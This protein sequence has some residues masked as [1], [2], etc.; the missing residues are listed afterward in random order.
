MLIFKRLNVF[1][2]FLLGF[3]LNYG[4]EFRAGTC[5]TSVRMY[6]QVLL[7]NNTFFLH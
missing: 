4:Q 6:E 7:F 5:T 2:I 3:A 1:F